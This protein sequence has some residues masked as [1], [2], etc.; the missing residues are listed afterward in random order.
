[1]EENKVENFITHLKN[2]HTTLNT[3]IK[4]FN[5]WSEMNSDERGEVINKKLMR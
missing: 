1:M 2:Y 5:L 3:F 4:L